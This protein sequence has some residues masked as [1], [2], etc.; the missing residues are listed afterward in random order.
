ML[1][2][3]LEPYQLLD[4]ITYIFLLIIDFIVQKCAW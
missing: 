1:V 3:M 4:D 2:V